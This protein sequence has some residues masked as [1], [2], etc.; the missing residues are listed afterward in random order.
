MAEIHLKPERFI[1]LKW[2]GP[3]SYGPNGLGESTIS[4]SGA[5][6][7]ELKKFY[8]HGGLYIVI[9]DHPVHGSRSLLYVGKTN[10]FSRRLQDEHKWLSEEWRIEIYLTQLSGKETRSDVEKLLIY[11]HSPSYNS[12]SIANPPNFKT[13]YRIWNEGRYWKLYPEISSQHDWYLPY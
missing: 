13:H 2:V 7:K 11:A 10:L 12:Q 3:F 6:K 5:R 9:G 8:M 4:N 1:R